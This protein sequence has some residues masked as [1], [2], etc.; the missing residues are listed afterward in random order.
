VGYAYSHPGLTNIEMQT[1]STTTVVGVL[2]LNKEIDNFHTDPPTDV[3]MKR[4]KDNI[5]NSFVFNFDTP[6]KVLR[7]KMQYEFYHYPLDFLERYRTE[8]EKVTSADVERVS[9]KYLHKEKL[10]VLVVGNDAEFDKPLSTLGPVEN[11]D[12]TIPPP[13]ASL[14]GGQQAPGEQQ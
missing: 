10:A 14:T 9:Q 13:P 6:E 5:L 4:A 8:V 7:E 1:K 12:I 3:E 2:A 11:V